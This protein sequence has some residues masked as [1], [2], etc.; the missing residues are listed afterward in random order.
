M[1]VDHT[2][3]A[4][5]FRSRFIEPLLCCGLFFAQRLLLRLGGAV[6]RILCQHGLVCLVQVSQ[7]VVTGLQRHACEVAQL[8]ADADVL[9]QGHQ[10]QHAAGA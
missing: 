5:Q 6:F 1:R 9:D 4:I 3:L 7:R 8:V 10:L 2:L